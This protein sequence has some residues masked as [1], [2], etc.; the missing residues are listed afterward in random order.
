MKVKNG[1]FHQGQIMSNMAS[2]QCT[3]IALYALLT[4][5]TANP[6][7][8]IFTPDAINHIVA[9]GHCMYEELLSQSNDQTPRYLGHWELPIFLQH[10]NDNHMDLLPVNK[11]IDYP[12]IYTR[13][14]RYKC[15]R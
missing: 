5:F 15:R 13:Q 7:L 3:A 2:F 12:H 14:G 10:N 4:V 11:K 1:N 8:D 6:R 9:N